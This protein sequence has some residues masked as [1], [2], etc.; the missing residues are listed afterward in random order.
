MILK[1][2]NKCISNI[3]G[4]PGLA[5]PRAGGQTLGVGMVWFGYG[6]I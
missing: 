5:S 2:N 1:N 4:E 6:H 3:V